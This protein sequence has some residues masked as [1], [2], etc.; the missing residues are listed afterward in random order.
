MV[1]PAST[2]ALLALARERWPGELRAVQRRAE[3]IAAGVTKVLHHEIDGVPHGDDWHRDFVSGRLWPVRFHARYRYAELL[4]LEHPS[5]VKVPWELSRLQELPVLALAYRRSGYEEHLA[6]LLARFDSWRAANPAGWGVNWTVGMEV[7][8]RAVNLV[9]ACDL[10]SGG[11][12]EAAVE[13]RGAADLIARHGRFLARNLEYSDINGNHYTACLLGLLVVGLALPGERCADSWRRLAL[14]ELRREVLRQVHP[15][16]VCHEGSIPYHRL[17]LELFLFAALVAARRGLDVGDA[18]RRRIERMAEATAALR[19]PDGSLPLWGDGDDGSVLRLGGRGALDAGGLLAAAGAWLGRRDLVKAAGEP[20]LDA[21]LMA[22]S[23]IA[24]RVPAGVAKAARGRASGLD[25]SRAFPDAGL[26]VLR[27]GEDFCLVDCGDV[28]LRGRGGHGH[29]DALSCEAWLAGLPVLTDTGCASYTRDRGSRLATLSA[30]SHNVAT[31]A[32]AEPAPFDLDRFP[33]AS[34]CPVEVL[35]WEPEVPA[36]TGRH[37]G[38]A[39]QGLAGA[40]QRRV[41]LGAV[42]G[43]L[44]ISDRIEPFQEA[45]DGGAVT[46]VAWHFQLAERW[47][48]ALQGKGWATW[49]DKAGNRLRLDH[50]LEEARVS[51]EHVPWYPGYDLEQMRWRLVLRVEA[52]LPLAGRFRWWLG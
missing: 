23:E 25:A 8:V 20:G 1:D 7:A 6:V 4:D 24:E 47:R 22:G 36:F 39:R 41:E 18:Y 32:G 10:L 33:H 14:R 17:V 43:G 40:Y 46:E 26:Y 2:D 3:R 48:P 45:G 50:D 44:E 11:P 9:V 51:L 34:S 38:Y 19:C 16:G 35:A 52:D 29:N 37:L 27:R 13:E 12:G 15:D 5:D 30:A 49:T 21:L 42:P 28:G 31:V